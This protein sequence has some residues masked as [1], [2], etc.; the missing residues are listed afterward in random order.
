LLQPRF[1]KTRKVE[2]EKRSVYNLLRKLLDKLLRGNFRSIGRQ[3]PLNSASHNNIRLSIQTEV[4]SK[5]LQA[6]YDFQA[7][8]ENTLSFSDKEL[9]VVLKKNNTDD[10]WVHV[11]NLNGISG[12]APANYLTAASCSVSEEIEHIDRVVNRITSRKQEP[13]GSKDYTAVIETLLETRASLEKQLQDLATV[14][15]Y[16][17]SCIVRRNTRCNFQDAQAASFEALKYLQRNVLPNGPN[18]PSGPSGPNGLERLLKTNLNNIP[19]EVR[20]DCQ[21]SHQLED[22]VNVIMEMADDRETQVALDSWYQFLDLVTHI[23]CVLSVEA[24]ERHNGSLLLRL[25]QH[26]QVETSWRKR[27]PILQILYHVLQLKETFLNV[28]LDSVLPEELVRDIQV[29]R[30]QDQDPDRLC[31]SARVLTVVLCS[32]Q[33]LSYN[34]RIELGQDFVTFLLQLLESESVSIATTDD[35]GDHNLATALFNLVLA[36]HRQFHTSS[37]EDTSPVLTSLAK[38]NMSDRLVEKLIVLYNRE[39]EPLEEFMA[40]E[41][42][43][44]ETNSVSCLLLGLFS[45]QSTSHLFYTADKEVLLDVIFRRLTDYGPG[46]ERR[47]HA[48]QLFYAIRRLSEVT[49]KKTD[50]MKGLKDICLESQRLGWSNTNMEKDRC[51]VLKIYHEFPDLTI[52]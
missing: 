35:Q 33:R 42:T 15:I 8:Y 52:V 41:P 51:V 18:G 3:I 5:M 34:Q 45:D 12:Y 36:I 17:L 6:L 23:D 22:L 24:V 2:R 29:T 21:D 25:V 16:Q 11:V 30:L 4:A 32:P 44:L 19:I 38:R 31:W 7:P 37:P 10:N 13:A 26:V 46:D 20:R 1:P 9:F 49:Y 48:L 14:Q 39:V 28:A 43:T 40:V 50:F 27:K 47:C